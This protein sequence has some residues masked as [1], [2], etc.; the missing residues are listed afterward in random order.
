MVKFD[1]FLVPHC[2]NM[3]HDS[4]ESGGISM[5]SIAG[6]RLKIRQSEHICRIVSLMYINGLM[7][8]RTVNVRF[9]SPPNDNVSIVHHF[10]GHFQT[11]PLCALGQFIS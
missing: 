8:H 1:N 10:D 5:R 9:S 11:I 7:Q 3:T 6:V 2:S 4:V